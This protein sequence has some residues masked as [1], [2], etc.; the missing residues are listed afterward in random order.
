MYLEGNSEADIDVALMKKIADRFRSMGIK[1]SGSMVAVGRH[2][3]SVYNNA[4]DMAVLEKRM[5]ALAKVFDDIILD[6][7]L[8]TTA[9]DEK[10]V[11][12]RGTSELGGL[13]HHS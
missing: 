9:T 2:G 11:K 3:P 7:W 4:N 10:S 6:D 13:P 12:D 5:R 1:V 8:F